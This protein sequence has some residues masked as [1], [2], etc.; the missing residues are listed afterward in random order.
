MLNFENLRRHFATTIFLSMAS[1]YSILD[2]IS[3]TYTV[4]QDVFQYNKH[5]QQVFCFGSE[6]K[7]EKIND[8]R[9]CSEILKTLE[10]KLS[11]PLS[12]FSIGR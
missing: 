1:Y 11:H 9:S 7:P 8:I 5:L 6:S 10:T 4:L 12:Y 2:E 3:Y